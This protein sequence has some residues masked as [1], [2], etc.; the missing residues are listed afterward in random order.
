MR[1][2]RRLVVVALLLVLVGAG[3]ALA[4]RG[5]PQKKINP[6][7]QARA[8]SMSLRKTDFP[9][10]FKS[11]PPS[12]DKD[13]FYCKAFDESDLTH[14]GVL[15]SPDFTRETASAI[16]STWSY[17]QVYATVAQANA[18]WQ[19][20]TSAAG[21]K[22]AELAFRKAA[23]EEGLRLASFRKLAFPSPAPRTVAYR[24]VMGISGVKLTYDIVVLQRGRAQV[25]LYFVGVPSRYSRAEEI[26]LAKLTAGR[27]AAAMP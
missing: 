22:C 13:D 9:P 10:T 17:A 3:T 12:K 6:A 23:K 18:S 7:D 1:A 8:K 27:M 24:A 4:A 19:R 25:P 5:D 21:V 26:S 20:G 11:T 14:T 16:W 15:E 2:V